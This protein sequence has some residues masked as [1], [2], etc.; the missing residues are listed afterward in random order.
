MGAINEQQVS[1]IDA[2]K[3]LIFGE[4]IQNIDVRLD[5]Y[6]ER[7]DEL[8]RKIDSFTDL[9]DKRLGMIQ[10]EIV[11]A[12]NDLSTNLEKQVKNV[13]KDILKEVQGAQ[14]ADNEEKAKMADLF[15]KMA[16]SL[17]K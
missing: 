14:K 12:N 8:E 6:E 1:K 2:I 17:K 9:V 7:I 4:E 10:K 15:S 11:N 16:A 5:V 13:Q 3:N